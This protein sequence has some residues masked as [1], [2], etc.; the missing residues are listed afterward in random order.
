MFWSYLGRMFILFHPFDHSHCLA[1]ASHLVDNTDHTVITLYSN[2]LKYE[3]SHST[4]SPT[5][6]QPRLERR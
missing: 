4:G 1:A 3:P 6:L 5:P 2:A